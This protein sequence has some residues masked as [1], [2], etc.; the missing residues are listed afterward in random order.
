VRDGDPRGAGGEADRGGEERGIDAL[1][2]SD[3]GGAPGD[4]AELDGHPGVQDDAKQR[5]A[6]EALQLLRRRGRGIAPDRHVEERHGDEEHRE[7]MPVDP[8]GVRRHRCATRGKREKETGIRQ[9]HAAKCTGG[10]WPSGG[11]FTLGF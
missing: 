1:Q 2:G 3:Q 11:R 5:A 10:L 6:L 8:G 4:E 9:L 7:R